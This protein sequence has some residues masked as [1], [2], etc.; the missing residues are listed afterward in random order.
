LLRS[1][2]GEAT[3]ATRGSNRFD[4]KIKKKQ[5]MSQMKANKHYVWIVGGGKSSGKSDKKE[6]EKGRNVNG[7][8]PGL[9]ATDGA[10]L[11]NDWYGYEHNQ[12]CRGLWTFA[13]R[14]RSCSNER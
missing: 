13:Y 10:F 1:E 7:V 4:V 3:A 11:V 9:W 8:T 2:K 5:I 14:T 12:L 6:G